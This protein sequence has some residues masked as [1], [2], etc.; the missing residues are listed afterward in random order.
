[1][2]HLVRTSSAFCQ[3]NLI[4][5]SCSL[6][7]STLTKINVPIWLFWDKQELSRSYWMSRMFV[8]VTQYF[9][10]SLYLFICLLLWLNSHTR[11]KVTQPTEREKETKMESVR[12]CFRCFRDTLIHP[13]IEHHVRQWARIYR[14]YRY[15]Q[16]IY[17]YRCESVAEHRYV[18]ESSD[19]RQ[20]RSCPN[21]VSNLTTR[22]VPHSI[23][24]VHS[25]KSHR[26][27]GP[28][29]SSRRSEMWNEVDVQRYLKRRD[30]IF[31]FFPWSCAE[32][33]ILHGATLTAVVSMMTTFS[34]E[35]SLMAKPVA[36]VD[37]FTCVW[38]SLF[39]HVTVD[40]L[41]WAVLEALRCVRSGRVGSV[42]TDER[43]RTSSP[44]VVPIIWLSDVR[45]TG[46][47]DD[48]CSDWR[49]FFWILL[50]L[51]ITSLCWCCVLRVGC[52]DDERL[53]STGVGLLGALT[54]VCR[55]CV[56]GDRVRRSASWM[57]S[58][59]PDALPTQWERKNVC[60]LGETNQSMMTSMLFFSIRKSYRWKNAESFSR[61]RSQASSPPTILFNGSL[62]E[63]YEV[64]RGE[65]KIG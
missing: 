28:N 63:E 43:R 58:L 13:W 52:I 20:N 38:E 56:D 50:L 1:M 16:V 21:R 49:A 12:S 8:W 33:D 5:S 53:W 41:L 46:K 34:L 60:A 65:T 23:A 32:W 18:G 48:G 15:E 26:F 7:R 3:D 14:T 17:I 47:D 2:L 45:L 27:D 55:T 51:K 35:F 25:A 54:D 57:A 64:I 61:I 24:F 9:R 37:L 39:E 31:F 40:V 6:W 62:V 11:T 10:L 29:W 59:V 22:F 44:F 36:V 19:E 42:D 30:R 4:V